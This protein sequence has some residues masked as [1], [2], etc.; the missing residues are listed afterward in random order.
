MNNLC[1]RPVLDEEAEA[2][3]GVLARVAAWLKLKGRRQRIVNTTLGTYMTWQNDGANHAVL[4]DG[5]IVG[6]FSLPREPL[7]EWPMIAIEEPVAWLRALAIDPTH[8]RK[9]I[10]ALAVTTALQIVG[11]P[12]PLYLDCVSD[13]LPSYYKSLGFETIACQTRRYPGEENPLD[14]TLLRHRNVERRSR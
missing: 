14:M 10:G 5:Q 7:D 1:V 3:F 11:S 8:H 9:G 6:I 4:D 13:F 12:E 2:A